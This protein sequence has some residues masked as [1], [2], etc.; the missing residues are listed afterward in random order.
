MT[1]DGVLESR[2]P[3]TAGETEAKREKTEGQVHIVN[4]SVAQLAAEPGTEWRSFVSQFSLFF[5]FFFPFSTLFSQFPSLSLPVRLVLILRCL[6][7]SVTTVETLSTGE[8]IFNP[9]L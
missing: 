1:T 8:H 2:A 7:F 4:H 6:C 9:S 3:V 5:L